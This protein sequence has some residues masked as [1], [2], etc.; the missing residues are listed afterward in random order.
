VQGVAAAQVTA[1]V[2]RVTDLHLRYPAVY[3]GKGSPCPSGGCSTAGARGR[4]KRSPSHK[5][6]SCSLLSETVFSSVAG[7][8]GD[9]RRAVPLRDQHGAGQQPGKVPY[10]KSGRGGNRRCVWLTAGLGCVPLY[11]CSAIL[12][13]LGSAVVAV[14]VARSVCRCEEQPIYSRRCC[15]THPFLSCPSCMRSALTQSL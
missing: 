3:R 10:S 6:C 13:P 2:S 15:A 9:P 4:V 7:P 11:C 8:E 14:T 1:A 5:H 12:A